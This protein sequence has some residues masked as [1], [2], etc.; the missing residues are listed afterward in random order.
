MK[1]EI[2]KLEDFIVNVD[3]LKTKEFLEVK[4]GFKFKLNDF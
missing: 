2:V 3:K 1:D 4:Q